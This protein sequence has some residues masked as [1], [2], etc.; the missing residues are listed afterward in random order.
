M[1]KP[2][3]PKVADSPPYDASADL[4]SAAVAAFAVLLTLL[5]LR[6]KRG[7]RSTAT[8]VQM[9][10][11]AKKKKEA[12]RGPMTILW[13]S[14]TGTAEGFASILM[15]EAR[16]HG[17]AA[18]SL[19]LEE[20]EPGDLGETQGPVVFLMATHGEGDPTDNSLAFY[21]WVNDPDRSAADLPGLSYAAFGL[22]NRQYEHFNSMGKWTDSRLAQLGATRLVEVGLGDDDADI[23]AD[24]EAWR[25]SL[26][27]TLCPHDLTSEAAAPQANFEAVVVGA[28]TVAASST[29]PPLA[30]LQAMHPKQKLVA[31]ELRVS[32]ELCQD[33]SQGSVLHMELATQNGARFAPD[34]FDPIDITFYLY[35]Y[36]YMYIQIYIYIYMVI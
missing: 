22:G 30:W 29:G 12:S 13:G 32:R 5:L 28:P 16:Q 4:A 17:Y 20:L 27:A 25:T 6:W 9:A 19:D 34:V 11:P 24:F 14:Q 36:I 23:E 18:R 26:W 15:R 2:K 7:S 31:A 33:A 3:Q 8:A 21:K 1:R 35:G 10:G